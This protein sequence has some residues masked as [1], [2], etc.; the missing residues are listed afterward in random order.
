MWLGVLTIAAVSGLAVVAFGGYA[1]YDYA[2]NNPAFCRSCHTMEVAWTRW[3][4]SE[5]RKID[6]HACHQQRVSESARQVVVFAVQQPERVGK[7]ADVPAERCRECHTSGDEH[8]R[9]VAATAGHTVHAQVKRIEC[10]TCHS[11]AIHRLV[12]SATVCANCHEAQTGGARAIKIPQMGDFHCVDCH[13]FLRENS[14]L[15]PTAET[16][17]SCHQGLPVTTTVGWPQD[18]SH[19]T[20]ACG[21]CHKP[22]EKAKP[23]VTCTACHT[24]PNPAIHPKDTVAAGATS[25]T[26]CT[27]CHQPHRWK[28]Q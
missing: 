1:V 20:L 19:A 11:T 16:C 26:T 8:W 14:P 4:S 9:Q 17:L 27:A 2:M 6:C 5:H 21:T 24:A 15:R 3:A 23:I 28:I 12:P 18:R 7:H 13:Q 22:H 10:V 25:F